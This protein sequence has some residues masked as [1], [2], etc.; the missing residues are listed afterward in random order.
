MS[1]TYIL[2][3]NKIFKVIDLINNIN[4]NR[5][6]IKVKWL[7]NKILKEKPDIDY[8][9]VSGIYCLKKSICGL[10]NKEYIDM[11]TLIANSIKMKKKVGVFPI[12]EY[13]TDIGN[14]DDL[15]RAKKEYPK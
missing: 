4:K 15:I 3:N 13:W 8:N 12:H 1:G 11:T 9:V 5:K 7:S 10:V 14:P 6:K 2:E